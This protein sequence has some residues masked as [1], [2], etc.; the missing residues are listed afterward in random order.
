MASWIVWRSTLILLLR[1]FPVQSGSSASACSTWL[2][3]SA[4][5]GMCPIFSFHQSRAVR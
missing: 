1:V 5:I 4:F 2:W 3:T